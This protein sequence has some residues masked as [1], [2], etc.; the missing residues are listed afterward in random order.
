MTPSPTVSVIV[1]N[2]NYAAYLPQRLDSILGQ[3]FR[4]FELIIL[5]DASTDDS[6]D[7]IDRYRDNPRVSHIIYNGTNTGSPFRQWEKGLSLARGRYVWIAEADDW[8]DPTFLQRCVGK[9]EANPHAAICYTDSVWTDS[10]GNE[11][12][13]WWIRDHMGT[14]DAESY[15]Y[16]SRAFVSRHLYWQN[17]VYNASC[18]LFRRDALPADRSWTAMRYAGDYM[19]WTLIALQGDIIRIFDRLNFFRRHIDATTK[20]GDDNGI[21]AVEDMH[22][23]QYIERTLGLGWFKRMVRHG[24]FIKRIKRSAPHNRPTLL[25]RYNE[26]IGHPK[27]AYLMF[28]FN[29]NILAATPLASG[30]RRDRIFP[31]F[32]H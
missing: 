16:D 2:Y 14:S 13:N 21:T 20:K 17:Y 30:Y 9:L 25:A 27:T 31:K 26:I 32:K 18:V 23:I 5:D 15:T 4:D 28:K 19:F 22:I 29:E 11:I 6:R 7:V 1:P 3:T 10:D 12:D 24:A 8:A